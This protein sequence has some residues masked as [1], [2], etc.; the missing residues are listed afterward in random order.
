MSDQRTLRQNRALHKY[1][2]ML[3]DA[4]N[5]AGLDMKKTLKP[6]I[7]I[8]WTPENVK[9]HLWRPIQEAYL[10][11]ESTTELETP[12]VQKVYKVLDRYLAEKHGVSIAFPCDEPP[13]I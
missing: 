10:T 1:F 13:M 4:L 12:D 9:N 2:S 8:P 11:K 3:A 5:D 6:E 7:E